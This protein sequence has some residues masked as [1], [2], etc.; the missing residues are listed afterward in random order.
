VALTVT[1]PGAGAAPPDET[2]VP[3][4]DA[5]PAEAD[6]GRQAFVGHWT[7]NPDLSEDPREKMQ[8]AMQERMQGRS[9]GGGGTGRGGSGGGGGMGR[10]GGGMGRGGMGS[11][12][13]EGRGGGMGR[14]GHNGRPPMM[15]FFSAAELTI[16]HVAPAVA[17]VEPDGLVRTLQPD[18]EKYQ[19]EHGEGEVKTRWTGDRLVVET[20]NERGKMKETWSVSPETGLLSVK[21]ELEPGAGRMPKVEVNRVY[22]PAER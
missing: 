13:G 1:A 11:G 19:V 3:T 5:V 10:G 20:K 16:P 18:G 14:G 15:A 4:E 6:P 2:A 22:D 12:G 21:L 7:L 9:G 17:I 8:Q